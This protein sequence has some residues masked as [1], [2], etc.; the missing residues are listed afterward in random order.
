VIPI[1]LKM[2][3]PK[4]PFVHVCPL[5]SLQIIK[6]CVLGVT[7]LP[8]RLLIALV[9]LTLA[10]ALAAVGLKG[11]EE[12]DI[13]RRPFVGWRLAARNAICYILRFMFFLC[14]FNVKIIGTQASAEDAPIL[15][16][17]PH[18]TFFDALAVAVMGAPSV[19]AKADTSSIPFWGSL[20]KYTQPVLVH[21]QDT[22]SRLNTIKQITERSEGVG[23]QQVLIFPEGTCTNRTAL[24]TFRLGSFYPG[25]AVQPVMLRYDNML[26]TVTWTWEGIEAWRVIVYSLCQFYTNLS[27]EF[28]PPYKPSK[29]EIEDPKLFSANV[30]AVMANS[31]GVS[32]TDC[33]YFDYL[34][35]EKGK[36][37]VKKVQKLQ[38]KMEISLIEATKEDDGQ[39]VDMHMLGDILGVAKDLPELSVVKELCSVGEDTDLRNLRLVTKMATQEDSL[40]TF[41]NQ[42]F[43]IYNPELGQENISKEAL[44]GVLSTVVFLTEKEAKEVMVNVTSEDEEVVS[45]NDLKDYL[46]N[47][48]PNYVKVLKCW[49]GGLTGGLWD[50]LAISSL[51]KEMNRRMEKVAES[52]SSLL[53]AGKYVVSDVSATIT[54]SRDKVTDALSS[55]VTSLHKRTGSSSGSKLEPSDKKLD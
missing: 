10:T 41:L 4:N 40:E 46:L 55:A 11:L 26:D 2:T 51:T 5:S 35:I 25:V 15:C 6:V 20:I 9:S 18:S 29:E 54:A 17:A 52:G 53:S 7:L 39:I 16:V 47:K 14:G 19:V 34:R 48:K 13:D 31:L 45:K 44:E 43:E 36:E 49:E 22:N 23:W 27:I 8:L 50:L 1:D 42:T 32:T 12:G 21:R 3:D 24:I 37:L 33:N 28:L 30:R 38:K